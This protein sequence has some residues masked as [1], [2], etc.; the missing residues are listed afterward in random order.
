[1]P[2]NALKIPIV[3]CLI[4]L[5]QSVCSSPSKSKFVDVSVVAPWAPTPL[6]IEASEYFADKADE[7]KFWEFVESLPNDIYEKTDKQHYDT[8]IELASK[9]VSNVQLSLIKFALSIRNFSPK[10]QA[11]KQLWQAALNF[12]C[13]IKDKDGAVVLIGGK[14]VSDPSLLRDAIE[15]CH[16][17]KAGVSAPS[18]Q[19]FDHIYP[20]PS[21]P[22][23]CSTAFLYATIGTQAFVNFHKY[24]SQ[25][26]AAG[27]V[28]YVFR[29]S[30]PG[31]R[32]EE[33]KAHQDMLL[34][35]YGVELAIKNMEYKAVDDRHKEGEAG[36]SLEDDLEDEVGGFDFKTLLQ[37]KPNLEVELLSFRDRLL[38]E[39]KSDEGTDIKV[40]AL[41]DLGIQASQR[42]LQADE[43]LRLI[44]DLSHNLPAVV[45]SISR[46]RVNASVR[47][48]LENNRNFIQPGANMV[49]VNGRQLQKDDM[50]PF[51]LYRFIRHEIN[52]IEKFMQLGMDSRSTKKILYAPAEQ[53][54]G[55]GSTF[56]IDV[57]NDNFVMWMN[58]LEKDDM[59]RQWPR[60]L[61]TLL[62][63]GW[64][65]Q[66][67]FIARNIWTAIFLVDPSD[68]QSLTFLSWAFEQMEQQLPVRFG[69]AFKYSKSLDEQ[70]EAS[71]RNAESE[72]EAEE[73]GD[74]VILH[75]LFRALHLGHGGRA[76]WS[77]LAI[78]AEGMQTAGKA[79]KSEVRKDSFK[80]AAKMFRAQYRDAD[81]KLM[82]A[83][84][85]PS[86]LNSTH[87][88][89]LKKSTEFVERSG[90]SLTE[91]VCVLNGNVLAGQALDPNQFHYMLQMQM[92]V[93]QR[94]A[95]FG[96]LDERRDLH[97]QIINHNGKAHRRFHAQIVSGPATSRQMLKAEVSTK[98]MEDLDRI[99]FFLCGKDDGSMRGVTHIVALDLSSKIGRDLLVASAKRMSQTSSDRCK[100]VRL[101]YLDNS[102]GSPEAEGAFSVLVEAIRS[103]K[104]DKDK[105]NKF[106]ELCRTIVKLLDES[107]WSTAQAHEEVKT[108][109]EAA[110]KSKEG[111]LSKADM[112]RMISDW[113]QL[114][115]GES[116]VSTSGRV[117]KVTA[118]VAFRMGDFVL[119]EDTEWNDRSKHVSSVLDVASFSISSDKVT[120]EYISSI[121]L[122][123]SNMIGIERN[124]NI[125]RTDQEANRQWTSR[126][127]GFK[128]G[129]EDSILQ[130]LAFID[131]LCAEA[132]RLSP[133]LMALAD[134][135]GAHIHVILNPV[136]E[137]GS[138]PIKGYYRYVLK[139]QLEFDEE[140]K[141]VSNTRATFSN[142]PM[143]KLL[144]MIIHPPDAW[145]VSASQAVHDIDNILLEK[146]SAH[147]TVLSAVYR[148]D[149]ILVTGHCIDDRREPP[150]GLQLNLNLLDEHA[151]KGKSKLVSDTLVMSNLGYYQLKARP[152]I[153]NLTMAEGKSSEIY[154]IEDKGNFGSSRVISVLSWEPDAFPTSVRK[155][156][157]QES[158][159]LQDA[160]GG[161]DGDGSVWS[162]LSNWF[163]G[164][165]A[166]AEQAVTDKS[167]EDTIHVFSLA[168]GHLYERFLKIMMLSVVRNTKSHVKFWLLQNFLSPQFK[169]FIPRMAKNFGFDYELVTYKWPSWLHEQTEKQRIIWGYKILMLDVLFPLSV[170]KI[171]YI[172]SDQVVRSDLKQLWDMNLRGRPY[173]YTPFCDDKR[174]IE[175]YRF[176]KQGFWQ[177]HL[178][179][180]KYHISALY[181]VDLN[182]FRAIGAGD[183][184]RVVYSQLSRDPN[185][186][187]NLDQD[188]PNYAQHSVPIFSLPQ[189]W[190]WCETWCSNSTKVK[191]KTIDLCNNPMTKEPKLDQARRIIGEWEELDKTISSLE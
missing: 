34:Q 119:A 65:G 184:L 29:H 118:D 66:L 4:L 75:R 79:S 85:K 107:A 78:Y 38:S 190:L 73:L 74:A 57:K 127:T 10:L 1:M 3:L 167:G 187:A 185:S 55:G 33:E 117:F 123:G 31:A 125:Q 37:R 48:E 16:P 64:P 178:G 124:D 45:S 94:M 141:L 103:M 77:F 56:K 93:L 153:F 191:A 114:T 23:H 144:S 112:K 149:H 166:T 17:A 13:S 170:P 12:G 186:L 180:M 176:W 18:I 49:H 169:A 52:V 88:A 154:E 63:R 160:K 133:M 22:S 95:Y 143:S 30:W 7:G 98:T 161:R 148:L 177:T 128:V 41:K 145:F 111:G 60:S 50:N 181:V 24:L 71:P 27:D 87:D 108:L 137:V 136:A 51:S 129:P 179:D 172:D 122:L 173:A 69:V 142:L 70:W 43:P 147:E 44:R 59:Y 47:A 156:K 116:A 189:E 96:Q 155:R 32:E 20:S 105:G 81:G 159:S 8:S 84:Y 106:L 19:E 171:I 46:M 102:E 152:G 182:R 168:S 83:K 90:L 151:A 158:K 104:N 188:L 91:P 58:D 80:R 183:E 62:Q 165:S 115:A 135:F 68:M 134:A 21:S 67:R 109:M 42:I 131:P 140:G 11:Y 120:S 61:D 139:P 28:K 14:C 121:A 157:G 6:I 9:I 89:F 15:S 97:N 25:A 72:D 113:F 2:K 26:A 54:E 174:E 164:D 92:M 100:R 126:M 5:V 150:A 76:A 138:L 86:L 82:R 35:G 39:A 101:A 53:M 163:S 110:E 36:S 132:Q 162:S 130:V 175:G 40:W 146:L 99:P